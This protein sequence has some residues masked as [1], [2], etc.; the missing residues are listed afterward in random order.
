MNKFEIFELIESSVITLTF[1]KSLL[2][3]NFMD[4]LGSLKLFL[5]CSHESWVRTTGYSLGLKWG[6]S[7]FQ[8]KGCGGERVGTP[9]GPVLRDRCCSL[10]KHSTF[11]GKG[12]LPPGQPREDNRATSPPTICRENRHQ[13]TEREAQNPAPTPTSATSLPD[14]LRWGLG[15]PR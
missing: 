9:P 10:W 7:Y 15:K 8:A 6:E 1:K 11:A 14:L 5:C 3:P 12:N 4:S 13:L 2:T